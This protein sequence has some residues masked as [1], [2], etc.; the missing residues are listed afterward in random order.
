MQVKQKQSYKNTLK[1]IYSWKIIALNILLFIAY[2][3]MFNY[4][5]KYQNHGIILILN[6]PVYLIY[7]MVATTSVLSSVSISSILHTVKTKIS[8]VG[9]GFGAFASAFS[10]IISGCGCSFPL[11]LSIVSLLG[12]NSS[13]ALIIN[14]FFGDNAKLIM[15]AM[16]AF[17]IILTIYIVLKF[18][19][20][21]ACK[22]PAKKDHSKNR[23]AN[24][25][26]KINK[27]SKKSH[28]L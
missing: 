20:D 4:F 12:I 6:V 2:Y 25:S 1:Q 15:A 9:T 13:Y 22:I 21:I 3:L 27:V 10:G 14:S 11:I 17:N 24:K 7:I 23:S 5:I 18:N 19:N 16:I 28:M 8:F 26:I